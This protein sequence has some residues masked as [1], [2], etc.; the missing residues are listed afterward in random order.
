MRESSFAKRFAVSIMTVMVCLSS[1]VWALAAEVSLQGQ[2][3]DQNGLG[4]PGVTVAVEGQ[5]LKAVLS[6]VEGRY[7]II[8]L[9]PGPYRLT[10]NMPG[11]VVI[12]DEIEINS[13]A[14]VVLDFQ[15]QPAFEETVVVSASRST[16]ALEDSPTT[17]SVIGR[18]QIETTAAQNIGDLLRT[19]PGV[20]VVQSSARDV[21][22][23]SRGSSD[24]LTGTQLAM[25]DGRPLFFDF[26]N[27]VFWDLLSVSAPD[28]Q[29]IEVVRGPA[30]AMWGANAVTGVVNVVTRPP[31]TSQGL[32][33]T[34]TGGLLGRSAEAGG[35]GAM[36]AFNVRWADAI[37]DHFAY[38]LSVGYFMSDAFQRPTGALPVIETPIKPPVTV[39]GGSFD[40][41]S[42]VNEG[43]AQPKIDLRIDQEI[44]R[45]G[46]ISYSAGM[47]GT[48]GILH[49]PIGPFE[50]LNNTKLL[51]G[52]VAYRRG[53]FHAST[54]ANHLSGDAPALVSVDGEGKPLRIE[55]KSG[56]YDLEVGWR[57]LYFNRHL[58]SFGGNFRHNTYDLSIAP[59]ADS[60]QQAGAFAQDEMDLGAFR[61]AL[62]LRTDYF[63]NLDGLLVSPRAAVLWMPLPGHSFK[64]SFN[65][66]FR[67]PSAIDNHLDISITG[68]YFPVSEFDPRLEDDFPIV[69]NSIGN[70][71][72]KEET[73][74]AW[75][76]GYSAHLNDGR[77]RIDVNAYT[78]RTD[79][80]ISI[81]PSKEALTLAGI[82]PYYTSENPPP[83]WP[84]PPIVLDFLELYD[85]RFPSTVM[86]MNI[87]SVR[88]RGVEASV[89]HLFPSGWNVY[90]NYS[91]QAEPEMLDPV[92][93]PMR[94]PSETVSVPPAHRFNLGLGYN[95]KDYLGS[96]TVNYADKA[97]FAQGL[98]PSYL[99]YSDAYT[100]VGASVGKRW[101]QGKFTTTLKALNVLDK[102][103]QQHVFGDVLRRTVMLE[104][105][106]VY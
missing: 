29:Q 9:P 24:F 42:Y 43:T 66:A 65:R 87:G 94:P 8:G 67:A 78:S 12:S 31:R 60:R 77:T 10:V 45:D 21:N 13:E 102:E 55:F 58:F 47:S 3:L 72:L 54:F 5:V 40:D 98:N 95:A 59:D 88:N 74:D 7:H 51:Y 18:G 70:L 76:I 82:D 6:Q 2:V 71:D 99:G 103:V 57:D 93:D 50:L 49:T 79:D 36:G 30:S 34:M 1:G 64:L 39:G 97:F 33:I 61:I 16:V 86:I 32:E 19:V 81:N 11:F 56:T 53:G 89:S 15:M 91:Y 23:A 62:A 37:N 27:L 69:V 106:W 90:A 38:R 63:D 84:L 35:T 25:V 83:G 73:I 41:V 44:S 4:L 26:F 14:P 17:I 52:Q 48:Q 80:L 101:K 104:L 46:S 105:R 96:L 100:L 75:E 68:G 28:V 20:N 92:G 22:I 85:I